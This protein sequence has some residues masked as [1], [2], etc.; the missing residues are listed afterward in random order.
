MHQEQST[1][2]PDNKLPLLIGDEIN[3][4]AYLFNKYDKNID[5]LKSC[6]EDLIEKFSSSYLIEYEIVNFIPNIIIYMEY[7]HP[8]TFSK[9][10]LALIKDIILQSTDTKTITQVQVQGNEIDKLLSSLNQKKGEF[11]QEEAIQMYNLLEKLNKD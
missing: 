10:H 9:N 4:I 2:L 7:K 8:E 5:T 3:K 11:S 6:F 1:H